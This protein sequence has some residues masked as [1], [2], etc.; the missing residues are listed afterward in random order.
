MASNNDITE[1]QRQ[2][3]SDFENEEAQARASMV[4]NDPIFEAHVNVVLTS[5]PQGVSDDYEDLGVNLKIAIGAIAGERKMTGHGRR[6]CVV[7]AICRH[8]GRSE[9][10]HFKQL[11]K[12]LVQALHDER[13]NATDRCIQWNTFEPP[14][15]GGPCRPEPMDNPTFNRISHLVIMRCD[16]MVGG[17]HAGNVFSVMRFTIE[18]IG[19]YNVSNKEE[20]LREIMVQKVLPKCSSNKEDLRRIIDANLSVVSV[21]YCEHNCQP[22]HRDYAVGASIIWLMASAAS[23]RCCIVQ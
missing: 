9:D 14:A 15:D 5:L 6:D 2:F 11:V 10:D 19:K 4:V 16:G 7:A 23:G 1:G 21:M 17:V 8:Y 3:V 18:E 20:M 22:V 12:D 13:F